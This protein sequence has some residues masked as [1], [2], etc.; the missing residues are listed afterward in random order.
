MESRRQLHRAGG[1]AL[2]A[3]AAAPHNRQSARLGWVTRA[4]RVSRH[5]AV[6]GAAAG[7]GRVT[8]PVGWIS[9]RPAARGTGGS[10]HAQTRGS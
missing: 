2:A 6:G 1:R 4:A 7:L 8:G 3:R 9:R 5:T 10:N